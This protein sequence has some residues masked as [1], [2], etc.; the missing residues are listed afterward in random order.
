M[1]KV[2]END[3]NI[4]KALQAG[5]WPDRKIVE[6]TKLSEVTI[7]RMMRSDEFSDYKTL[8]AALSAR[9]P[10]LTDTT[11]ADN[12]V[13]DSMLEAIDDLI[14]SLTGFRDY[15]EGR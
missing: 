15:W 1:R 5:G 11:D 3:F 14:T 7:K 4:A 2:V 9:K 13:R 10:R 6:M 12:I 8:V